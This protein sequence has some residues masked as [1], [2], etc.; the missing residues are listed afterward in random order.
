MTENKAKAGPRWIQQLPTG[1]EGKS[2]DF[3]MPMTLV[4]RTLRSGEANKRSWIGITGLDQNGRFLKAATYG[5]F[6]EVVKSQIEGKMSPGADLED[7]GIVLELTGSFYNREASEG[8]RADRQFRFSG[9]EFV[10]GPSN[11]LFRERQRA[12]GAIDEA[13]K[14][15]EKGDIRGAYKAF[16]KFTCSFASSAEPSLTFGELFE[17]DVEA[18]VEMSDGDVDLG[19]EAA[20]ATVAEEPRDENGAPTATAEVSVPAEE[21]ALAEMNATRGFEP[22][23]VARVVRPAGMMGRRQVS[24][25]TAEAAVPGPVAA[26]TVTPKREPLLAEHDVAV[27]EEEPEYEV[28]LEEAPPR[29][30]GLGLRR[31]A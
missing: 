12:G 17:S 26:A 8:A 24:R 14:L 19:S 18:F 7:E 11:E 27:D 31:R 3:S 2:E 4:V 28:H 10:T 6:A 13:T 29:G 30:M 20:E 23:T 1:F 16:E 15:L 5:P 25:P 21:R 22:P 9:F